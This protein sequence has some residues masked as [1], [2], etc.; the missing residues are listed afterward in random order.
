MHINDLIRWLDP[1]AR[2]RGELKRRGAEGQAAQV[3]QGPPSVALQY[4]IFS[5]GVFASPLIRHYRTAGSWPELNRGLLGVAAFS[6]V[7]GFIVFPRVIDTLARPEASALSR[8]SAVFTAG[9]GW[10]QFSGLPAALAS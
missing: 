3:R 4:A 5:L 2:Y 6:L 8:L 7:T 10:E 9:V 1:N